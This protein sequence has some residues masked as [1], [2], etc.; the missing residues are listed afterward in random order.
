MEEYGFIENG[1]A[2]V[3]A[4]LDKACKDINLSNPLIY[5]IGSFDISHHE[6]LYH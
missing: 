3:V 2:R 1:W 6:N 5:S 4:Y